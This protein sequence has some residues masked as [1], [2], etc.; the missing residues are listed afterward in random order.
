MSYTFGRFIDNGSFGKIFLAKANDSTG[1][2]D[3]NNPVVVIKMVQKK[4]LDKNNI[5]YNQEYDIHVCLKHANIIPIYDFYSDLEA[6]YIVMEYARYGNLYQKLSVIK[7]FDAD[8]TKAI[9]M[10]IYQA[11]VFCHNNG[12][13][14]RDIKPENVLLISE[15]HIKITDFGWA[16]NI[17]SSNNFVCGTLAYNSPEMLLGNYDEKIDFWSLGVMWYEMLSGT[18]P[19]EHPTIEAT[20]VAIK[21]CDYKF[22]DS[23]R[24]L[25]R[26]SIAKLI[27]HVASRDILLI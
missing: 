19:F 9:V 4:S 25:E 26:S 13:M 6:V 21:T 10:Q 16:T 17:S 14:H 1:L 3:Q 27:C 20:H 2:V 7:V 23:I 15:T 11:I 18:L 5:L 8:M 12:I 24:E 22:P